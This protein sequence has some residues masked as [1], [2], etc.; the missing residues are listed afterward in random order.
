[1]LLLVKYNGVFL[2]FSQ[3]YRGSVLESASKDTVV[4]KVMA[5][6]GDMAKGPEGYGDIRY[7]LTGENVHL[8]SIDSV[9][10]EIKV[11]STITNMKNKL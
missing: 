10:G 7:T 2:I 1:M 6:D 3:S 8:F 11:Y 4:L 9:T 5:T